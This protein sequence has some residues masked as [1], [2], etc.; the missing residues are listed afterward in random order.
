MAKK[1]KACNARVLR[2]FRDKLIISI[3]SHLSSNWRQTGWLKQQKFISHSFEV[4]K[5]AIIRVSAWL[6]SGEAPHPNTAFLL[7]L[8]VVERSCLS[9]LS[10][11]LVYEGPT[12]M[13]QLLITLGLGFQHKIFGRTQTFNPQQV[14]F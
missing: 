11:N 8:H 13:T 5:P 4:W 3:R 14:I 7:H 6:G 2:D 12:L 1:G 9:S 10:H